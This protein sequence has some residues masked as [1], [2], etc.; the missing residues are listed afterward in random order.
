MNPKGP[1][2]NHPANNGLEAPNNVVSLPNMRMRKARLGFHKFMDKNFGPEQVTY[3]TPSEPEPETRP[4]HFEV[5]QQEATI[6]SLHDQRIRRNMRAG[7]ES[8]MRIL[9][10]PDPTKD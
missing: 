5:G 9:N 10:D 1:G 3:D 8:V 7:D 2:L 6:H 4:E